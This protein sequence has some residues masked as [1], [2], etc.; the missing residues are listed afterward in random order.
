MSVP[1]QTPYKEYTA[2]GITT[3]FPLDFDVLEQ[4]HLIVLI[5]DLDPVV[6]SWHLDVANDA[7][8]FNN[9]PESGSIIKIRRDTPLS[10]TTN[11][12]LYDRSFLPDPVNKDFDRIWL[13]LQELGLADW[14]LNRKI[15]KEVQD[16]ILADLAL[17]AD[18]ILRD[19]TLETDYIKRDAILKK[20]IDGMIAL[21]TGNPSFDG[22][23]ATM[24]NDESGKSQQQINT[25]VK[26][27]LISPM[28]FGA[29]GDGI[30]DDSI[31]LTNSIN[32]AMANNA[33]LDGQG[34]TYA[35]HSVKF[36]SN[37]KFK[38]AYLVCNKYDTDLISVL[39]CTSYNDDPRWLENV[40]FENIHIDG[41]RELHTNIKSM[42]TQEDGGRSG[43][44]F[45]RPVNG[46][47]M[48][49]CSGN[50]CATEGIILFPHGVMSSVNDTIKNVEIINSKFN[51]NR[52]HGGSGNSVNGL[53]LRNVTL[54]DNGLDIDPNAPLNSGLRGD[55]VVTGLYGNGWDFEEYA[56]GVQS[57]DLH[58]I[59]CEML[60]NAKNGLL[61]LSYPSS[62]QSNNAVI[63]VLGGSYD[64][65][66][67]ENSDNYAILV[68]TLTSYKSTT[69]LTVK[70]V[71]LNGSDVG[72]RGVDNF[73][74]SD[75]ING[76]ARA[77]EITTM[78]ASGSFEATA[79][80][81]SSTL[82]RTFAPDSKSF[83]YANN[84]MQLNTS[85]STMELRGGIGSQAGGNFKLSAFAGSE[86]GALSFRID[87][88][89][90]GADLYFSHFGADRLCFKDGVMLALANYTFGYSGYTIKDI[91]L[92]NSPIITSDANQKTLITDLSQAELQVASELKTLIKKYKM[93]SAV[94]EK[95]DAARWHF[96]V[97]AQEVEEAF[98]RNGLN[99]FDYGLLCKDNV[100]TESTE[101]VKTELESE[102]SCHYAIRYDE[103]ITFILSAM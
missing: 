15:D 25:F 44:R 90:G 87:E 27:L 42:T 97:I 45:I 69:L 7:V 73:V 8:V 96:G 14:L 3:V 62:A 35:C 29:K 85:A 67:S 41:K 53:W 93:H 1:E 37:V 16:R 68:T 60:G 31:A 66:I 46:L 59:N 61:V 38:N 91:Y 26:S 100:E 101:E 103:L 19:K 12:Q 54:N 81:A 77:L 18:Y 95:D 47:K 75:I 86:R 52:R 30:T 76:A 10:R 5:N 13:K 82:K 32:F 70:D 98:T 102:V 20:Y 39:E 58:F 17:K 79:E 80:A 40:Y 88:S 55:R 71:D 24:V 36:D 11:Y 92:A 9:A 49:N 28:L 2:N 48:I 84:L 33:M 4:D 83:S 51:G 63:E 22:I 6:G 99:A 65:G 72:A 50:N 89:S 57:T 34:K 74:V 43:F 64:A 23:D 56:E 21:V 78:Y 94:E